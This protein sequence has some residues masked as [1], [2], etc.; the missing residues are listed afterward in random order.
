M[1]RSPEF[2]EMPLMIII[3][4]FCIS[5]ASVLFLMRKVLRDVNSHRTVHLE[6]SVT[7]SK[8]E[9]KFLHRLR[10]NRFFKP[11]FTC[12]KLN[13]RRVKLNTPQKFKEQL[14]TLFMKRR[15][16]R[17]PS[18]TP[19]LIVDSEAES[20][21]QFLSPPS[22]LEAV[23]RESV[24][25]LNLMRESLE[26]VL[27]RP[28]ASVMPSVGRSFAS[29]HTNDI[30][31]VSLEESSVG[32]SFELFR[33]EHIDQVSS[34][35]SVRSLKRNNTH[36]I[37]TLASETHSLAAVIQRSLTQGNTAEVLTQATETRKK[38]LETIFA[39]TLVCPASQ[40]SLFPFEPEALED[41]LTP[42]GLNVKPGDSG[43]H[44]VH[45]SQSVVMYDPLHELTDS[46]VSIGFSAGDISFLPSLKI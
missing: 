3:L 27:E 36:R 28:I 37:K 46:Y 33:T 34:E 9:Y 45:K 35:E 12:S 22:D 8:T 29:F 32:R 30:D 20:M 38:S 11:K 1:P 24:R 44:I 26:E 15:Q 18:E 19:L 17:K 14:K 21:E 4:M 39:S 10:G 23:N 6:E 43:D 40:T 41:F 31:Q 5:L 13:E 2:Q 25:L 7:L 16:T 42:I